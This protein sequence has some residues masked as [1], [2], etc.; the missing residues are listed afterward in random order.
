M[1]IMRNNLFDVWKMEWDIHEREID[2]NKCTAL[3][4]LVVWPQ[5]GGG[6]KVQDPE[7]VGRGWGVGW[8]GDPLGTSQ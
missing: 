1:K 4:E 2:K 3:L 6:G 5:E 8:V 7:G